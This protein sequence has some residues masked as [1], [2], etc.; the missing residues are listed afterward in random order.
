M[1]KRLILITSTLSLAACAGHS[2]DTE[3][4]EL[5]EARDAI[6]ASKAAGAER[7]APKLQAEAVAAFYWAA[8]EYT[9]HDIHPDENAELTERAVA[10]A[11]AAKAAAGKNCAPPP[12][13]KPKPVE[14]IKLDGIN[15]PHDSA[16]LTPASIAILDNAV[17][18]LKR[19]AKINVEVA[20]HT[21]SSGK[22]SYNQA[23]SERRA[24]SVMNYLASKGIAANRL[25]SKGYGETQPIT[26]NETS[27]G[28]AQN[29]RVE[30]RVM[31]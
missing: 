18:T 7:C 2:M 10:K 28:R 3:R 14:I 30:L 21:D 5:A 19:R 15:F 26:S 23:L 6:A 25:T 16:E 20:A 17:A 29:R 9:E 24:A 4:S 13:P 27:D 8:H 22:D 31:N 11:K 12:K 1:I